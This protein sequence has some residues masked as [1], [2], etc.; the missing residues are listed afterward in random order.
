MWDTAGEQSYSIL[1]YFI[2]RARIMFQ[3][4]W[5]SWDYL[6]DSSVEE[7]IKHFLR[8]K[9][10]FSGFLCEFDQKILQNNEESDQVFKAVTFE[11]E[12]W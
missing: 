4:R 12:V 2:L 8:S 6:K 9:V 3:Y 11:L 7:R 5:F 1:F 10:Y